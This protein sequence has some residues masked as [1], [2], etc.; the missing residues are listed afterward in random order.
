MYMYMYI[1]IY[2]YIR[3]YHLYIA[4]D[5]H[6]HLVTRAHVGHELLWRFAAATESTRGEQRETDD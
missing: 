1:Y 6:V 5:K 2:I 4:I 3:A